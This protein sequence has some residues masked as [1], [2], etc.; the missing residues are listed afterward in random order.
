VSPQ[1]Q[2]G[3]SENTGSTFT[4]WSGTSVNCPGTGTSCIVTMDIGKSVEAVFSLVP[5]WVCGDTLVDSRDGKTYATVL[6]GTQCWFKQNLGYDNGCSSIIWVNNTDTGWCGYYT[7][8]PFLNEGLL[9]QWSAAMNGSTTAGAQGRCP[10][11][12]HIPTDTE[13]KTLVEGQATLGCEFST[14]WQC[15]PAGS[16]LSSYTLNGDNSSGFS[17]LLAGYRSTD[18]SFYNRGSSAY[19]WSSLEGGTNAWERFLYSGNATVNRFNNYKAYG[20]SV[21]CLKD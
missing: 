14:G 12:W 9:Y 19:I 10:T 6:I 2:A 4:G 8:G 3:T 17:G 16:H 15:S 21:R 20:F 11:G 5:A 1:T 13:F 7:E 18:G